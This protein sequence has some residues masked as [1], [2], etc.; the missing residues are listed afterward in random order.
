MAESGLEH[1]LHGLHV[2][3]S[4]PVS[5]AQLLESIQVH[6]YRLLQ[7]GAG[8]VG[9]GEVARDWYCRVYAPTVETIQ[10]ER[11]DEVCPEVTESS[12]ELREGRA[13]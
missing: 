3:F 4:R 6:G 9:P 10:E 5:Y 11:L 13:R 2:R 12:A 7:A 1:V 8:P